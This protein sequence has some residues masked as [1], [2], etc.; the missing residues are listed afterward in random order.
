MITYKIDQNI[1]VSVDLIGVR[2]FTELGVL[3]TKLLLTLS[4]VK[5]MA[6]PYDSAIVIILVL[7][8]SAG[9]LT[10][11][12]LCGYCLSACTSC[13]ILNNCVSMQAFFSFP[14]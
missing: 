5:I 8:A 1:L 6:Q 3:T 9:R 4:N 10:G 7:V 12:Y 2:E 11:K 13:N 14:A